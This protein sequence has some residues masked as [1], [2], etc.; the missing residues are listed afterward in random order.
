MM[1]FSDAA[2][3]LGRKESIETL[4]KHVAEKA[5]FL[6]AAKAAE[7]EKRSALTSAENDRCRAESSLE[8]AKAALNWKLG[9]L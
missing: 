9:Q 4:A 3:A 8:D 5:E 7:R 2:I 1:V 6:K